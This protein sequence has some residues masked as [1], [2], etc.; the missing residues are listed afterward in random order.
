LTAAS[1]AA[2]SSRDATCR[3]DVDQR[4]AI[5]L[6][7]NAA[8]SRRLFQSPQNGAIC[9][10]VETMRRKVETLCDNVLAFLSDVA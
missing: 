9:R 1:F 3:R 5:S 6:Q 4:G 7:D 2:T 10:R 8:E